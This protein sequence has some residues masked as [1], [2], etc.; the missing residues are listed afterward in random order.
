M[1]KKYGRSNSNSYS[2]PKNKA[3]SRKEHAKKMENKKYQNDSNRQNIKKTEN[4]KEEK[5]KVK[6]SSIYG[7]Q[8]EPE[9]NTIITTDCFNELYIEIPVVMKWYHRLSKKSLKLIEN[10]LMTNRWALEL[11]FQKFNDVVWKEL[12]YSSDKGIKILLKS[13]IKHN[14][15]HGTFYRKDIFFNAGINTGDVFFYKRDAV[16]KKKEWAF[17]LNI[18]NLYDAYAKY[19]KRAFGYIPYSLNINHLIYRNTDYKKEQNVGN[20]GSINS[21]FAI[22]KANDHEYIPYP[23]PNNLGV[24][25]VLYINNKSTRKAMDKNENYVDHQF[26]KVGIKEIPLVSTPVSSKKK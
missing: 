19:C 6:M 8:C 3:R 24:K 23:I 13:I 1:G 18:A 22:I 4:R 26:N 25:Y 2:N 10:F 17:V 12:T 5:Y 15:N 21:R 9:V 11:F 20:Y 16:N 14:F 7:K